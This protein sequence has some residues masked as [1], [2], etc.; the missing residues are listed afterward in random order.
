MVPPFETE[1]EETALPP[2]PVMGGAAL[3]ISELS[4][5][6]FC[7]FLEEEHMFIVE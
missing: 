2:E 5:E 1:K 6:S 4:S 3:M 7:T